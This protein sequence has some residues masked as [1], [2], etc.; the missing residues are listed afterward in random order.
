MTW[1]EWAALVLMG[2]FSLFGLF[3]APL[4]FIAALRKSKED[5]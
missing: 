5:K 3:V 2:V 1:M 4:P